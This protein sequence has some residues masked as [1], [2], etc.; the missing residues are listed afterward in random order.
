MGDAYQCRLHVH[1]VVTEL[2]HLALPLLMN[3]WLWA[4]LM[5]KLVN[6]SSNLKHL[7]LIPESSKIL[8]GRL[9]QI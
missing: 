4:P 5:A 8:S 3:E 9:A 7:S 2:F 1:L 6:Q